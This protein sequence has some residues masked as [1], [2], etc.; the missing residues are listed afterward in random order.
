[1][2]DV[3]RVIL[4]LYPHAGY[5]RGLLQ[6]IGRYARA[7]GPWIFYVAG[8]EPGLPVP[9]VE[10]LSGA[11]IKAIPVGEG[12]RRMHL[13][14]LRRWGATGI[15]GRLQTRELAKM[16]L[17][18]RVPVIAMDLSE[19]QLA[20]SPPLANISEI[21]P[22]S[23]KAGRMA[24]EHLLERG[25]KHFGYCG[26]AGRVWSQRRQKGFCQRL[27]EAGGH[28][29][30]YETRHKNALLWQA[31]RTH[32]TT[33]LRS[34]SK[35]VGI[36]ACNDIRGRQVLEASVLGGMSTP[37]EV[38]VVG[39]DDD[40]LL[41]ELSNPPLSSVVLNAE[42]GG[43]QAA[44]LLDGLMSHQKRRPQRIDVE[45]LWVVPRQSTEVIA[46]DDA[47]VA[48]ALRFIRENARGLLT[49]EDV[50]RH[51]ALS[52]RMLEIRFDH[53]LGRSIR[54]EIQRVRLVWVRQLLVET[55][56]PVNKIAESAGFNSLS[57]LSK[58]FHKE[59]GETLA[60]YRRHRRLA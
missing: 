10:A 2:G 26:Y 16:V 29:H 59:V 43:Y 27:E 53:V 46:V 22:D 8:D 21:R 23:Y 33:W 15:I 20:F 11:R 57:Y 31:E 42:Q 37:D 14:D 49:V 13:P 17:G 18:A 28:Y 30:V 4:L 39:V 54:S 41:C 3:P 40:Q 34:L 47:E 45:P 58:V 50:V 9:E 38:A 44:E 36:M 60:Q 25:F 7:H 52:R 55:S 35:P 1:M 6:G 51:A 32:V 56:M 5:D 24:A 48:A 19:E 12:R